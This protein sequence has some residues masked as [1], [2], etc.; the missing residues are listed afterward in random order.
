MSENL[1]FS[2]IRGKYRSTAEGI[3]RDAKAAGVSIGKSELDDYFQKAMLCIWNVGGG[4]SPELYSCL[5][6]T[7]EPVLTEAEYQQKLKAAADSYA[8]FKNKIPAFY[9]RLCDADRR[10]G[11]SSAI[12]FC[13]SQQKILEY[14][15]SLDGDFTYAEAE[16]ITELHTMLVNR[17]TQVAK[18]SLDSIVPQ[19]ELGDYDP[20]FDIIG[21]TMRTVDPDIMRQLKEL[22]KSG[23]ETRKMLEKL[24]EQSGLKDAGDLLERSGLGSSQGPAGPEADKKQTAPAKKEAQSEEAPPPEKLEDVLAELNSLIGLEEIKADVQNLANFIKVRNLRKERG[25]KTPDMSLHLVFTG[26]PGTGKSTVARLIGRIYRCLGVLSKGQLIEVDRSGLVGGYV[27]QTAIKTQEVIQKALGGVLFIDEAYALAPG[28]ENDFGQE[29]I[30]TILKAMEDHRDDLVVIVAGYDELMYRFINSNPGLKSRFNKYFH[31]PDY[32]AEE[33]F[34]IFNL[35]VKKG[36]YTITEKAQAQVKDYLQTLYLTRG[37]NFGNARDVRNLFEKIIAKQA[38]RVVGIKDPTNEQITTI[39]E[40]DLKGLI[41][42]SENFDPDKKKQEK[43]QEK[44]R[45]E[46]KSKDEKDHKDPPDEGI[47]FS[48]EADALASIK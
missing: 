20:K 9:V 44:P 32:N 10:G 45:E 39:T 22:E 41:G 12:R 28:T 38:N 35:F 37:E 17:A 42:D 43:A 24:D 25:I 18:D 33:L 40:E 5:S 29:A 7:D 8:S 26:N 15:A 11:T 23:I 47:P 4:A 31:F 48:S 30:N 16:R 36:N 2:E 27:G 3:I 1:D 13:S 14:F 21:K 34:G 6:L 46:E 19:L